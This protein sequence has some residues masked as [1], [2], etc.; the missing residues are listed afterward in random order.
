MIALITNERTKETKAISLIEY[1]PGCAPTIHTLEHAADQIIKLIA[2]TYPKAYKDIHISRN[3]ISIISGNCTGCIFEIEMVEELKD[4]D[5]S[6]F[7]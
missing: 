2:G 5:D 6:F 4:C 1:Y 7:G 3:R